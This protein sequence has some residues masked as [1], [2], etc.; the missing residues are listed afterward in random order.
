MVENDI[1]FNIPLFR[2]PNQ[3]KNANME[4]TCGHFLF[5]Y[6]FVVNQTKKK[7]KLEIYSTEFFFIFYFFHF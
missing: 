1:Y 5:C 6:Y 4:Y 3:L 7:Q 2:F